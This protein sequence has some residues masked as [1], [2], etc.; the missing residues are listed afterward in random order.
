TSIAVTSGNNLID[1][2]V[3]GGTFTAF[4]PGVEAEAFDI[5][6]GAPA[7]YPS[8]GYDIFD[9]RDVV[10]NPGPKYFE[11]TEQDSSA[12]AEFAAI[13]RLL[14]A[15]VNGVSIIDTLDGGA[16]EFGYVNAPTTELARLQQMVAAADVAP[17]DTTARTDIIITVRNDGVTDTSVNG[18]ASGN[19]QTAN[20]YQV[21]DPV[22][23]GNATVT[24]MGTMVLLGYDSSAANKDPIGDWDAMTVRNF[25]YQTGTQLMDTYI[26]GIV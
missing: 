11:N 5:K 2:T 24:Y 26:G 22:G 10:G 16:G 20:W 25:T 1:I 17:A 3:A 4:N 8:I 12:G 13:Q 6:D 19:G 23:N 18:L 9:V 15:N 14:G 7:I 21:N